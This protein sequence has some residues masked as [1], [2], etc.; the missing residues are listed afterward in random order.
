M[1][2]VICKRGRKESRGWGGEIYLMENIVYIN[3]CKKYK[4]ENYENNRKLII[5]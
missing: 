2:M 3:H 5:N 4:I 1:K